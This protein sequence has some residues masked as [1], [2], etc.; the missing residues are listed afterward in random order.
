CSKQKQRS[1]ASI[2]VRSTKFI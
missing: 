1:M 2:K